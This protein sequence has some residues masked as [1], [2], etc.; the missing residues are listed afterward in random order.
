M[1]TLWQIFEKV[2]KVKDAPKDAQSISLTSKNLSVLLEIVKQS[3]E[4]REHGQSTA[5]RTPLETRILRNTYDVCEACRRSIDDLA[6]KCLGLTKDEPI[7]LLSRF[8]FVLSAESV[9]KLERSLQTNLVAVNTCLSLLERVDVEPTHVAIGRLDAAIAEAT[10]ILSASVKA[11]P[12][13][14]TKRNWQPPDPQVAVA[15]TEKNLAF[16]DAGNVGDPELIG[17]WSLQKCIKLAEKVQSASYSTPS[18]NIQLGS[19]G[20]GHSLAPDHEKCSSR[21]SSSRNSSSMGQRHLVTSS[22]RDLDASSQGSFA[23]SDSEYPSD[24]LLWSFQACLERSATD[25][26]SASMAVAES[27][28]IKAINYGERLQERGIRVF[29]E[30][31]YLRRRISKIY[32]TNGRLAEAASWI[33]PLLTSDVSVEQAQLYCMLAR[34]SY[35]TYLRVRQNDRDIAVDR[36]LSMA[37]T[38]AV[39]KSYPQ[40]RTL[41][42]SNTMNRDSPDLRECVRLIVDIL[43]E[44]GDMTEADGWRRQFNLNNHSEDP[45]S[46][47]SVGRAST[48]GPV[49]TSLFDCIANRQPQEVQGLLDSGANTDECDGE[50]LTPLMRAAACQHD[51]HCDDCI[52]V[53]RKLLADGADIDARKETTG[54]TALHVAVLHN[55]LLAA[56]ALLQNGADVNVCPSNTPLLL[57]VQQNNSD[58][59]NILL[60]AH[61]NTEAIDSDDWTVIHHAVKNS[62]TEPLVTLLQRKTTDDLAIDL[63]ARCS[64]GWTPLMHLA[65]SPDRGKAESLEMAEA[66]IE[67]GANV[68]ATTGAGAHSFSA[69]CFAVDGPYTPGRERFVRLLMKHDADPQLVQDRMPKRCAQYSILSETIPAVHQ[70]RD[71]VISNDANL[72]NGA[73][74]TRRSHSGRTSNATRRFSMSGALRRIATLH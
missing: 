48:L 59:V 51:Q 31:G 52:R 6:R 70:R 50:G 55:N 1:N 49:Q 19:N 39:T 11:S 30:R 14:C 29:A 15:L 9:Q 2:K 69:L 56:H 68:N 32:M 17:I 46:T 71:S 65:E 25:F 44:K 72:S 23:D 22:T 28:I 73:A 21:R 33:Q 27:N 63:D 38:L 10:R 45:Y 12:R 64:M 7:R 41:C 58:F 35:E 5:T 3:L 47:P 8:R 62:T 57:A 37:E 66:L 54:E 18:L 36:H 42:E 74:V 60:D 43:E 26:S 20:R 53:I 61:A 67:H 24:V 34:L 4:Q 40:Y 16:L 13:V